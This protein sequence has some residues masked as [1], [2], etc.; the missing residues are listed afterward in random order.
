MQTSFEPLAAAPQ[1]PAGAQ[2]GNPPPWLA[3]V[4]PARIFSDPAQVLAARELSPEH[5][6]A[7][8]AS[9]ASDIHAV[10]GHPDLRRPAGAPGPVTLDAILAALRA[11]DDAD[12]GAPRD[13]RRRRVSAAIRPWRS[14]VRARPRRCLLRRSGG[15][16]P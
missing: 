10:E 15:R 4:E 14:L 11:L 12:E 13:R 7:I 9:W 1:A 2:T 3:F 5:K 6:R 16:R 8:L